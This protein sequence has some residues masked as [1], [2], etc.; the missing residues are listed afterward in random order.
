MPPAPP[1]LAQVIAM[2]L[3]ED[4]GADRD[5]AA[6]VTAVATVPADTVATAA[7][8]PRDAGVI[9]GLDVIA[10]TYGQLDPAVTVR[11]LASD[12]DQAVPGVAVAEVSGPARAVLAGERTALNL[13]THLSGIAT[14]TRGYVDAVSPHPCAVRDT[15][16][17]LPGLRTLQKA[18]VTAGG[19]VNH[20]MSLVDGM[21][22]K[23]NHVAAA[24]G[25]AAAAAAALAGAD[26]LPVQIE[27]D[28]LDQ[29]DVAL[30]AGAASVL[31]DNFSL[32]D[33]R[34]GVAR[35]RAAGR[36]VFVESS[37]GIT[38]QTVRDL[39]AAGVDAVA[40]G[41]LTHSAGAL[42]I[43]LDIHLG[44]HTTRATRTGEDF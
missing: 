9:A 38:L 32:A 15:R 11:L 26:G 41:A 36:A 39:A 20:R 23:D 28:S 5:V 22:V 34:E 10:E 17:T 43:G 12:G 35:C 14:T 4:L 21:L 40:V 42:D 29:L 8:V 16:K 27:V 19:G 13:L 6:D 3:A 24:G 33:T 31:L 25:M 44:S 30:Q 37:G 1:Q 18:A 2:G 7:F